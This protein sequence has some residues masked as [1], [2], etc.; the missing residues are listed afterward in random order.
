MAFLGT[1]LIYL[2]VWKY[3]TKNLVLQPKEWVKKT[4]LK[5]KD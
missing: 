4:Q 5:Q 1:L 3:P 2:E